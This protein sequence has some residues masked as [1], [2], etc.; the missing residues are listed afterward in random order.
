MQV[1]ILELAHESH[2]GIVT[3]KRRLRQKVWWPG[4]DKAA[5]K[6]VKRCK[7]CTIVSAL[8]APEPIKSTKMPEKPWADLAADFIGPLPSQHNLLVIV[9]YF[10]RFIEVVVMKQTTAALTVKAFHE[11]FCRFG[12]PVTLKTDNGP[13]PSKHKIFISEELRSFCEQFGIQ[14]RKTTPY[15]PQANGEVERVNGMI[16]KHLKISHVEETDWKWDLRMCVLMYNSTPHSTTGI[17]PSILMFGRHMKDKLP[18]FTTNH[19][20]GWEEVR[21]RDKVQKLKSSEYTDCRRRAKSEYV[22]PLPS[23]HEPNTNLYINR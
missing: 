11:T 12:F 2:P 13:Q 20:H 22:F 5:E 17:A 9:D 1:K 21:D 15:W 7:S 10:S 18:A 6:L 16:E 4:M 23:Y 8:D 19:N 14:Q 3:M